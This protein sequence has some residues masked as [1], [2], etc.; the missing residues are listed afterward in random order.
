MARKRSLSRGCAETGSPC[1]RLGGRIAY[2]PQDRDVHFVLCNSGIRFKSPDIW[3]LDRSPPYSSASHS[4]T[5]SIVHTL[6]RAQTRLVS[7]PILRRKKSRIIPLD[8][9]LVRSVR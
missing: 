1:G 2:K 4:R 8:A 9:G 3:T 5:R 6:E 7:R